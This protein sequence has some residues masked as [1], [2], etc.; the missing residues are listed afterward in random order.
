LAPAFEESADTL[1]TALR[2]SGVS[3]QG[4]AAN[5]TSEALRQAAQWATGT[6]R[7]S[8]TG[9][10][11]LDTYSNSFAH[12]KNSIPRPI[13][14]GENSFL[15]GVAD[16]GFGRYFGMQSDF[17]QRLA[18][19]READ[20][21]ASEAMKAYEN[22]SRTTVTAF[23]TDQP[24]PALTANST[25]VAPAAHTGPQNVLSPHSG[26]RTGGASPTAGAPGKGVTNTAPSTGR[27]GM[28]NTGGGFEGRARP[29]A[30]HRAA[31]P[32]PS[33]DPAS[34]IPLKPARTSPVTGPPGSGS[35]LVPNGTDGLPPGPIPPG[36]TG[37]DDGTRVPR[38]QGGAPESYPASYRASE[39][40]PAPRGGPGFAEPAPAG[41]TGPDFTP[42]RLSDAAGTAGPRGP[43]GTGAMPPMGTAT[44]GK[45]EREHRNNVFIPS[46]EPFCVAFDDT[47]PAVI[48]PP[49][50][51]SYPEPQQ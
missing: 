4:R 37:V 16:S 49:D 3:W 14:I 27:N 51:P 17:T 20:L 35:S 11:Q 30:P 12:T 25:D 46:D 29:D 10:T 44:A 41:R 18:A 31:P 19:H 7:T 8:K 42:T 21:A 13:D 38:D 6:G 28:A 15:G 9:G 45:H 26:D 40:R 24:T 2:G 33:T 43:A 5:A 23:L 48:G 22:T 32:G 50:D 36:G 39:T 1:Q 47:T 34:W